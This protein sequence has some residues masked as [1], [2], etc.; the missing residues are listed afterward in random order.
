MFVS[1]MFASLRRTWKLASTR[2]K[3]ERHLK[4]NNTRDVLEGVNVTGHRTRRVS[5]M[6]E[7]TLPH[8]SL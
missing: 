2:Q 3:P 4:T 8:D 5:I 6:S 1:V 7:A